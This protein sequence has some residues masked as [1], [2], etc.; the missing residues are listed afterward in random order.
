MPRWSVSVEDRDGVFLLLK[1]GQVLGL[2]REARYASVLRGAR[3]VL[4]LGFVGAMVM[5]GDSVDRRRK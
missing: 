5:G 4:G 2:L 1:E 3:D